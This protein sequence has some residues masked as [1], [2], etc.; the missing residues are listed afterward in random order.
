MRVP[1]LHQSA[2][3]CLLQPKTFQ[4]PIKPFSGVSGHLQSIAG[5]RT[6]K[7]D[8]ASL[9]RVPCLTL[10]LLQPQIDSSRRQQQHQNPMNERQFHT[11]ESHPRQESLSLCFCLQ[12]S[13]KKKFV[14]DHSLV[15]ELFLSS[16]FS[17]RL[18]QPRPTF[19]SISTSISHLHLSQQKHVQDNLI[20]DIL[21]R[22]RIILSILSNRHHG[23]VAK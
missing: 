15:R 12:P 19:P 20:L 6:Q 16:P 7:H 18:C 23:R 11:R 1:R 4:L 10:A 14:S 17:R 21:N 13:R 9:A 2:N 22:H 8:F 5:S 3:N